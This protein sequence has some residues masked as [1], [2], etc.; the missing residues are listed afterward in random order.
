MPVK[1]SESRRF[2]LNIRVSVSEADLGLTSAPKLLFRGFSKSLELSVLIIVLI[3]SK[4]YLKKCDGCLWNSKVLGNRC[5]SIGI[6]LSG[7]KTS[8]YGSSTKV[9]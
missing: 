6:G 2:E 3:A 5:V 9:S 1:D 7:L 8:H 4:L